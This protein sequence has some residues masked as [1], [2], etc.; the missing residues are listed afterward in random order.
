[1]TGLLHFPATLL[2]LVQL[3]FVLLLK[4]VAFLIG[5]PVQR[6]YWNTVFSY[7]SPFCAVDLEQP[8]AHSPAS[9]EFPGVV[10]LLTLPVPPWRQAPL[11]P[12]NFFPIEFTYL[13]IKRNPRKFKLLALKYFL[14][15][16]D[17][18]PVLIFGH[19]D[20]KRV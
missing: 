19:W 8:P 2:L 14:G 18:D 6:H 9:A 5:S 16:V 4:Q 20:G 12:V 11:L 13:G 17:I 15:A 3:V 1:M 10:A 7:G